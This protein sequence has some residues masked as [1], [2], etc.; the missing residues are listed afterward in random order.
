MSTP[1]SK[2]FVSDLRQFEFVSQEKRF[3]QVRE[4]VRSVYA[5]PKK[6]INKAAGRLVRWRSRRQ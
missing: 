4:F 5:G 3:E 6:M 1:L 2:K